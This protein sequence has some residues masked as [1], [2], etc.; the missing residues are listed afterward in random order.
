MRIGILGSGG[1]GLTLG[2]RLAGLGHDVKLG[3]RDP[4][5]LAAWVAETGNG[6]SAGTF[7]QAAEHAQVAFVVTLWQGTQSALELAGSERLAGKVVVDVTN[8]LDFSRGMPPTLAVGGDTSAG[9]LVQSWLP[10]ARVVK[11][12]NTIG[13]HIMVDPGSVTGDEPTLFIAGHDA[14]AKGEVTELAKGFGWK[15]VVDLGGLQ[16]ARY[17]EPLAMVWIAYLARTQSSNHALKLLR[18]R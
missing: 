5:K 3:S 15:D 12:F 11:A 1:V 2:A 9:E 6:A 8:P 7:A 4:A 14:N 18:G 10:G 16:N 13:A 17:L